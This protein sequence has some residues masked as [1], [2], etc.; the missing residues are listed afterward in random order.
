M[1]VFELCQ[2][3]TRQFI[4]FEEYVNLTRCLTT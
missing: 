3:H 1:R 2:E 4:Q